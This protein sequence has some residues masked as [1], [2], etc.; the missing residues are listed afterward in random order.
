MIW[1]SSSID[2]IF[3]NL[4]SNKNGLNAEEARKRLNEHGPN[5]LP[6]PQRTTFWVILLHQ[7]LS[8][9][10]YVLIGAGILAIFMHE[11][12]DA[13]FIFMILMI[14]AGLGTYQ[15]WHAEQN[16]AGLQSLISIQTH[17]LREGKEYII[18][19]KNLVPGDIIMLESGVKVPADLR[20]VE[21]NNLSIDEAFLTGESLPVSKITEPLDEQAL[22]A[23]RKNIAFAGSVVMAGRGM[24]VVVETGLH[25]EVGRIAK[26]LLVVGNPKTPLVQRMEKFASQVTYI[27]LAAS[28]LLGVIGFYKGFEITEILFYTVALAVSAIPEGLP[29]AITVALSIATSRMVKKHVIVKKLAAVEG[30]GSCTFIAS[31]KTGTL[32][33]NS[34]TIRKVALT[35]GNIIEVS[36][37]GYNGLGSIDGDEYQLKSTSKLAFTSAICNEAQLNETTNGDWESHGDAVDIAFLA[38]GYKCGFNPI[39]ERKAHTIIKVF[40]YESDKKYAACIYEKSGKIMLAL[41]GAPEALLSQ[42][43]NMADGSKVVP[44]D[45]T[46]IDNQIQQLTTSGYRVLAVW[47]AILESSDMDIEKVSLT[48]LGLAGLYD[49]L[50]EESAAAIKKC[51][52][53][54]IEVAM[55]TGDHPQT[56]LAISKQLGLANDESSLIT[57]SQLPQ[58]DEINLDWWKAIQHKTVFARVSPLQKMQ[59]VSTLSANGH[60]VAVTGDGVNDVPAL[61]QAHIGVAMGSG[62]DLAKDTADII[63]TDD[64]FSSI[65]SGVE[66]GRF[67]YDNIRKVTA[68]LISTGAAEIFIFVLALLS[69]YPLP[70]TAIQLLWLNLVTNGIQDVSLAYEKGEDGIMQQKPRDKDEGIFN[71]LMIEQTLVGGIGIGAIAFGF[72]VYMDSQGFSVEHKRTLTLM[73][74]VL[75]QNIHVFSCRSERKSA[76]KVPLSKNRV[77]LYGVSAAQLI[78]IIATQIPFMQTV[79]STDTVSLKEWLTL[80][81]L[82]ALI[83]VIMEAYKWLRARRI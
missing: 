39:E 81:P 26:N 55:V 57:G 31:D 35:N 19:A 54:G 71:R 59:I 51:Q 45:H 17:A 13:F 79:L 53:A 61:K 27:V 78:H 50:R 80:L 15:E 23:E 66:E 58:T 75:M 73:L 56:A 7:F 36:G 24:G 10:I 32:T 49:P 52:D 70:F 25:T 14:N 83:L 1:H 65:V 68:L 74:M 42:T 30:L 69:N 64:N 34:Q 18:D 8:P 47:E 29:I 41:K 77:L 40:P 60:F 28:V 67:A 48:L 43:Q 20:L 12:L 22:I 5:E 82:A 33:I 72:W 9:L 11:Y 62:T 76:F 3:S 44:I 37:S 4:Q 63:I 6:P 38:L 21:V 2:H 16:A 46:K